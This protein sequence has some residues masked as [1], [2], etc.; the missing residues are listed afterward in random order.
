M[1]RAETDG[2]WAATL[3]PPSLAHLRRLTDGTGLLQHARYGVPDRRHGYC[4]DDN[5][6]ALWLTAR[7]AGPDADPCVAGLAITYAAFVDHAWDRAALNGRGRFENFMSHARQWLPDGSAGEDEDAQARGVLAL[8]HA[9][10][11]ALPAPITQWAG[12][13]LVEAL[14]PPALPLALRSPRAWAAGLVACRAAI[15]RRASDAR[16]ERFRVEAAAHAK[17][18]APVLAAQLLQRF[19]D[20]AHADWPWFEDALAYDNARLCEGALAGARWEGELR[21][22]GLRS[23]DWL[24]EVQTDGGGRHRPFGNRGFGEPG[25]V[26][27]AHDQQ[28]IDAWA[29]F[30]A[31]LLAHSMTGDARWRDRA[32]AAARWFAGANE[33]GEPLFDRAGGSADGIG[34][35]GIN[36]N[37][38]AESTLAWLHVRARLDTRAPEIG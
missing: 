36:A 15:D 5:A 4:L 11:S 14:R 27:A 8:A 26:H 21:E 32:L 23:L 28:P 1:D 31:C 37:R 25:L 2:D 34:P 22:I 35:L 16:T 18:I 3:P 12:S 19:R 38:G 10:A 9:T 13:L 7:L 17:A 33:T 24:C 29:T 30:D 20:A 6:R